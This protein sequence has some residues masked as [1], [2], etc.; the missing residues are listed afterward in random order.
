MKGDNKRSTKHQVENEDELLC[1][2][3]FHPPQEDDL[4]KATLSSGRRDTNGS[5]E[6]EYAQWRDRYRQLSS[7]LRSGQRVNTV[8]DS[9][10]PSSQKS[11]AKQ[12]AEA[13]KCHANSEEDE[14]NSLTFDSRGAREKTT[15]LVLQRDQVV[16]HDGTGR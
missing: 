11:N 5:E 9:V 8:S 7:R 2:S 13:M 6:R 14:L 3:E 4:F 15:G 1:Q 16:M 12:N 10:S